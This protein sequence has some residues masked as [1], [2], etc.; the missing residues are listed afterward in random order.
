M[1]FNCSDEDFA[2]LQRKLVDFV[3]ELDRISRASADGNNV[4]LFN[5]Q[6][7]EVEHFTMAKT[8]NITD[9]PDPTFLSRSEK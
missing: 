7:F 5:A 2:H 9:E 8:S 4:F 3:T 6:L 1:V